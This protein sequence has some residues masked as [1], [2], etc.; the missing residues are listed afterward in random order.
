MCKRAV[1]ALLRSAAWVKASTWAAVSRKPPCRLIGFHERVEDL[2]DGE[3]L[4][5]A[6]AEQV[7]VERRPGD[8]R[9]GGVLEAGGRVDDDRRIAR[10]GDDR[11]L[12]AGEGGPGDR[13][14]AGD[15]QDPHRLVVERAAAD[16]SVGGS[17]IVSRLS[18]PIASR[19]ALLN[20]RTPSAAILASRGMGVE[21]DRVAGGQHVD[22]VARERRQAVRHRRDGADD[23]EGDVVGQRQAVVARVV[24]GSEV[25]DPRHL[26]NRVRGAW[27]SCGR[28]GRSGSPR[29]RADRAP[30]PGRRRSFGCTR[31]PCD[32]R[33]AAGCGTP[34]T[35]SAAAVTASSTVEKTPRLPDEP[36]RGLCHW[37]G[38][39]RCPS[40]PGPLEPR[41]G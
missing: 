32:G 41:C 36:A 10:P 38:R 1:V 3:D 18:M 12:L 21:D 22:R 8:D 14:P 34:G 27:R 2:G 26:R 40:G 4:L 19:I 7:V 25:L 35:P 28:A 15:D 20:R 24:V 31:R 13:R 5:L 11:P 30:R 39:P 17:M 6:D 23:S 33:P 16:S 37:Q 29:A 9:L